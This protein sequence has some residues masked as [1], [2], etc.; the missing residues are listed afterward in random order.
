MSV[1]YGENTKI[2]VY[3]LMLKMLFLLINGPTGNLTLAT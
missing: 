2:M 3:L 1:L